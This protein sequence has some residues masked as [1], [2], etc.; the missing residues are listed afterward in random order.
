MAHI[1]TAPDPHLLTREAAEALRRT[2][3]AVAIAG[4]ISIVCGVIILSIDWSLDDLA[5]FAGAVFI[6]EGLVLALSPP[7]DGRSRTP[8]VIAGI[9][10]I[11]AGIAIMVWPEPSLLVLAIFIG[12]WILAAGIINIVG[13]FAN[14]HVQY[15]WI[16]LILGLFEVPLG[17]WALRRPA[18]T[19]AVTVLAIGIWAIVVGIMRLVIAFELRNLPERVDKLLAEADAEPGVPTGTIGETADELERLVSLR[20]RGVITEEDYKVLKA[21]A[22]GV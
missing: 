3:I 8:G 11:I 14:R 21:R 9:A 7:Y 12:A 2:W 5:I 4:A 16:Y 6:F 22:L 10:G 15:W 18:V 13:A 19:L 1:S 20:D 17:I